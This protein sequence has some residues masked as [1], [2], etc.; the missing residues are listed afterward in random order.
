MYKRVELVFLRQTPYRRVSEPLA[1]G[2]LVKLS[3]DTLL[4]HAQ[5]FFWYHWNHRLKS[6]WVC[7]LSFS[8]K[9]DGLG[10][11]FFLLWWT[12]A[13]Q[14]RRRVTTGRSSSDFPKVIKSLI[15][16]QIS[17]FK[18]KNISEFHDLSNGIEKK[19]RWKKISTPAG[20]RTGALAGS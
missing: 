15:F 2:K 5:K 3:V 11:S 12:Q 13:S 9:M 18:N 14:V 17:H 6:C 10:V 16:D 7:F 1:D 8:H 4:C 20:N 19:R